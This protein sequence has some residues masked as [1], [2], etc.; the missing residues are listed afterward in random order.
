MSV[1]DIR[2]THGSGKSWLVHKLL[3]DYEFQPIEEEG[4][5]IGYACGG[6]MS[7]VGKYQTTCGGCDAIG[8]PDEIVRRIRLFAE[9]F[10]YVVLEGI[11]VAHTWKRYYELSL[12]LEDYR[13][14][15]L[16][17]PKPTCIKRVKQRRKE[18][19]QTKPFNPTHLNNDFRQ[20]W[21]NV[22]QKALDHDRNV[23]ILNHKDPYPQLLKE[24]EIAH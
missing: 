1:I 15:F 16:D 24:L 9:R 8:K 14:C 17:T 22:R 23:V 4:K 12:E 6:Y 13:F 10:H 2:G 20:I 18:K 11:L 7:V 19:G 3:S 21:V 5:H